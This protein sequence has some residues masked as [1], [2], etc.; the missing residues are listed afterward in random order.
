MFFKL[1]EWFLRYFPA[2]IFAIIGVFIGGTIANFLF[3]NPVVTALLGTLGENIGFYG[4]ILYKDIQL[5]K[6]KDEKITLLGLFK[7]L[8]N[9]IFE[10]GIAEY[11]DLIIRPSVMYYFSTVLGNVTLGLLIG[12]FVADITFYSPAI[13]FYELRKR[14]FQD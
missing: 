14:I 2:E 4:K 3:H 13:L 11:L 9:T 10:F 8:R 6:K 7:V 1:K 5:R 12:K